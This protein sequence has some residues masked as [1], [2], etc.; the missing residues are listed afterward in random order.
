MRMRP[1]STPT[2]ASDERVAPCTEST[3]TRESGHS[4]SG[5]NFD[6]GCINSGYKNFHKK[7]LQ[8]I[9][10]NLYKFILYCQK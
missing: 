4:F 1:N 10:I 6:S 2:I 9:I 5:K 3:N 8:F 7:V